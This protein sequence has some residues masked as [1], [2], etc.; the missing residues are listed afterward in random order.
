MYTQEVLK[1]KNERADKDSPTAVLVSEERLLDEADLVA[2]PPQSSAISKPAARAA[3]GESFA[4]EVK[5]RANADSE[6]EQKLL[7]IIKL[8]QSGD[9]TWKTELESFKEAYP[10]YPLPKELRN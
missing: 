10:D 5:A 3:I 4:V 8:K 6:A 1:K 2:D 9:E 7:A